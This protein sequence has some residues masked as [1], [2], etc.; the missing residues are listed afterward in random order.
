MRK[1]FIPFTAAFLLALSCEKA[2]EEIAVTEVAISQP[3]AELFVGET[4]QLSATVTP[5]DATDQSISWISTSI[6]IATVTK[7]GLVTAVAKGSA[8]IRAV[9]G[10]KSASCVIT[11]SNKPI[12]V[13]SIKLNKTSLEMTKGESQTLVA[14]VNPDNAT[15]KT[16]SWTSSESSVVSVDSKGK[17]TAIGNGNATIT[18]KANGQEATC[19]VTVTVPVESISLNKTELTLNKGD[20]ETLIATV[21]PNDATHQTVTWNSSDLTVATVT[22]NGMVI[23]MGGGKATITAR[24]GYESASCDITVKVPVRS[25]TLSQASLTLD[26]GESVTLKA[27]VIPDDADNKTVTWSTSDESIVSVDQDGTVHAIRQGYAD[28][29]AKV[30]DKQATCNVTVNRKVTSI[31][32]DKE[33]LTLLVGE[34]SALSATVLPEDAT[35]KTITWISYD[36]NVATVENGIVKGVSNG[37][38]IITATAGSFSATCSVIVLLDSP[39]GVSAVYLGGNC[40]IIDDV[41]QSGS[42]LEYRVENFSSETIHIVSLQM[43]DG[44]TGVSEYEMSIDT[45]IH[46]GSFDSWTVTIGNPGIHSPI[47][48]FAYTFKGES[49]ICEARIVP[50]FNAR[51]R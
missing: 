10:G 17:V 20:R 25:I 22:T 34:T 12:A 7:N 23:A 43:I 30:G 8:T 15:D 51:R 18:A 40:E 2:P 47:A 33:S 45:D 9:V 28:I 19:D 49:Y 29:F 11:V 1:L 21:K 35:D 3:A 5:S 46:P 13:S 36:P 31:T 41:V 4:V 50:V 32:L 48:R 42:E 14:T 37:E 16:V 24:I 38:T 27:T 44:Q 26:E 6:G 39:D